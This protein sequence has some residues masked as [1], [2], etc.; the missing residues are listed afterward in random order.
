MDTTLAIES[1]PVIG[2]ANS[3]DTWNYKCMP[4]KYFDSFSSC[5]EAS[6]LKGGLRWC[7]ELLW[8][9]TRHVLSHKLQ[10][11]TCTVIEHNMRVI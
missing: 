3:A 6:W 1:V 9:R 10:N 5:K 7:V 11:G 4:H 8:T 2:L